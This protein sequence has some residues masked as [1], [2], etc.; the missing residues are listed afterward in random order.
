[1]PGD[2]PPGA[3]VEDGRRRHT[4]PADGGFD[5]LPG[6][7]F[8]VAGRGDDLVEGHVLDAAAVPVRGVSPGRVVAAIVRGWGWQ[9]GGLNRPATT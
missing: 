9:A 2:K 3:L 4:K 5:E 8:G 1:M 7:A 6:V